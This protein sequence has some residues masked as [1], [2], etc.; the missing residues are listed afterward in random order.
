MRPSEM[1]DSSTNINYSLNEDTPDDTKGEK[2]PYLSI[3]KSD[4]TLM[5]SSASMQVS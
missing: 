4:A 3:N 5:A 1:G 2:K